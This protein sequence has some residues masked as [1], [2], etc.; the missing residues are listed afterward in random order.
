MPG[1]FDHYLLNLA[2]RVADGLGRLPAE[3]RDRH[4]AYLRAA[5]NPDGGFSGREGGSDLYYTGFAL[6]GLAVLDVLAPDV[7]DRAAGFLR[8]SLQE[9]ASVIDLFSLLYSGLLVQA[10]GGPD[11]FADSPADWPERVCRTLESFRTA[12]GGYAKAQG[13]TSGSTYHTFLVA[14]CYQ[15]LDRPVP[16]DSEVLQFVRS[17]QREDGG[18]VE[19][20]AMRRG[21]TNPTAAAVGV[22]MMLADPAVGVGLEGDK[23]EAVVAF[24]AEMPSPEGGFKANGR[25]PLA[26]LLSTFTGSWTLDQ[27]GARD[28]V[29]Q[30]A[31]RRYTQALERSTGGFRG[32]VWDEAT[33]VEYTFYGLGCLGLLAPIG[34]E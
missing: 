27:L 4:A 30:T 29:D 15:L 8:R 14:L 7:C 25:A 5:Q 34:D 11:V 1:P 10:G 28:R 32:G 26:D 9:H 21:G 31:V 3:F 18:F 23:A 24:L 6:R 22:L 12:D 17:R 16:R 19:L 20:G 13:G 2:A 33:D